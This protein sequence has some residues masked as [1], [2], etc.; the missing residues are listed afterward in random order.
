MHT[1]VIDDKSTLDRFAFAIVCYDRI[2][3]MYILAF[4]LKDLEQ[5]RP[6]TCTW[7]YMYTSNV[8]VLNSLI[9][10]ITFSMWKFERKEL[11]CI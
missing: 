8:F 3:S 4:L 1:I 9:G 2:N 11:K 7:L 10:V 6:Q 5:D